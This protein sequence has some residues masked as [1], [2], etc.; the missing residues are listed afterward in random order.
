MEGPQLNK[1]LGSEL[2]G[3]GAT[4]L[5]DQGVVKWRDVHPTIPRGQ[6]LRL[7]TG[8]VPDLKRN[9]GPQE[10]QEVDRSGGWSRA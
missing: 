7:Q 9:Q 4:T 1:G 10:P 6:L 2:H 3:G 8:L 5:P